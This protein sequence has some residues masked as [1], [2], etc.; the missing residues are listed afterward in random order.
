M[1]FYRSLQILGSLD[2][3]IGGPAYSV[4][5]LAEHLSAGSLP[6]DIWTCS[7]PFPDH[8]H[9][10]KNGAR[11]FVAPEF[12]FSRY[13]AGWNPFAAGSLKKVVCGASIVHV[14]GLWLW[15]GKYA[16]IT[17]AQQACPLVISP[18]GMLEEWAVKRSVLKKKIALFLY[19]RA[20]FRSAALFHATS[21]QEVE[22]IRRF[23]ITQPVALIPNGIDMPK[24]NRQ[25]LVDIAEKFNLPAGK[26]FFLFLSRIHPK[27]G[28][29]MLLQEWSA[30][31]KRYKD[32]HLIIAGDGDRDYLISLQKMICD[33]ELQNQVSWVGHIYGEDKDAF[34]KKAEFFVLP[35]YSENFGVSVAEALAQGIPVLTTRETPWKE[36]EEFKC[37]WWIPAKNQALNQSL[38]EAFKLPVSDLQA[39]G[40]FGVDLVGQ[41][42]SWGNIS[43][44]MSH[45]YRWLLKKSDKPNCVIVE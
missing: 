26:R 41:R 9:H 8:P 45:A 37:G 31:R 11:H 10:L 27:K 30:L 35:S 33:Y 6:S 32:W 42:Y 4:K 39:M 24:T 21:A 16:R 13:L 7:Y 12:F 15:Y 2:S 14:H 38:Q 19:E 43:E 29:E 1:Q 25:S 5:K 44:K 36:I 18:R 28:V 20:N 40:R 3:R 17:A 22:S 34:F 23:G